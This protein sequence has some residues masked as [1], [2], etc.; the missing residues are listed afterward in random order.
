MDKTISFTLLILIAA[1]SLSSTTATAD[2]AGHGQ[3][4]RWEAS[5]EKK[6]TIKLDATPPV[7][8]CK[9]ATSIEYYQDDKTA[10]IDGEIKID[11]CT[12]ANGEY[13]ISVRFRDED[14]ETHNLDFEETW[15]RNSA[16]P[17]LI[18]HVYPMAEN[19]DLIRVR[20][21]RSRCVCKKTETPNE[22][23]ETSPPIESRNNQ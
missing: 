13:T 4:K 16:A 9:S 21:R 6:Y 8:Y 3:E 20:A 7:Q 1:A 23:Q 5:S 2:G 11:G 22:K 17:V 12:D 19:V 14:G 18:S 10:K 15:Q